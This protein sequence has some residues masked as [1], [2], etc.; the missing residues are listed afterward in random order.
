MHSL[1]AIDDVE[2][3]RLARAVSLQA[4]ALAGAALIAALPWPRRERAP[5]PPPE[6]KKEERRIRVVQLP[7]PPPAPRLET[8][9]PRPQPPAAKPLTAPPRATPAPAPA[10]APPLARIAADSTAMHGVRMRVLVPRNPGELAAHLRNAGGCLVV[11]RLAGEGAEV[12]SVLALD[13]QRVVEMSGPPC[14]GVP[15]LVRDP[16]LNAA[17][18]DPLG[19][20]RAASP[21]DDVV[22]QVLLS[23]GLHDTARA[24]LR[25]RFGPV[26][27][28]EMGRRAA[29][30]GYELTCFA[31]PGGLL[32][33][34]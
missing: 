16:A 7:R 25:A 6:P 13:G 20:A 30:T 27:E 17:L 5:A 9:Q 19:R 14:A 12:L 8:A 3:P 24:A 15:R 1:A 18:G 4:L 29:E 10:Q 33:C 21:G 26:S 28:E 31:E 2:P 34:E 32:R 22:L 11:S 23:P